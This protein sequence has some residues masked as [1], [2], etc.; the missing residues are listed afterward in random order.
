MECKTLRLHVYEGTWLDLSIAVCTLVILVSSR[1]AAR[2]V[3]RP[4]RAGGDVPAAF[5]EIV[6]RREEALN[7]FLKGEWICTHNLFITRV[8]RN[9]N[10]HSIAQ[11]I[12]G[13]AC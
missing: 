3:D 7:K 12:F 4:R 8:F 1:T 6:S 13:I 10:Q 5:F 2:I 11:I 9:L